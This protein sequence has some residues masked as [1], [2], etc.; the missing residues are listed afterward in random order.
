MENT[1]VITMLEALKKIRV[2]EKE[3]GQ[4]ADSVRR[5]SSKVSI[6]VSPFG[7]NK[8]QK[9]KIRSLIQSTKDLEIEYRTLK[10]RITY[11]NLFVSRIIDGVSY[12]LDD[13]LIMKRKTT[14]MIVKVINSLSRLQGENSLRSFSS[15][16]N[17]VVEL[18]YLEQ[19][20]LS[21]LKYYQDLI[22][23]IDSVLD[24]TLATQSL[25][26]LPKECEVFKV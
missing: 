24:V 12:T 10:K 4:N 7:D 3:I 14:D 11:T 9:D 21:E 1:K 20:K 8:T 18:M 19:D 26:E 25:L 6:E 17:A 16:K 5:Y 13:L 23:Y 2:I 15:D 22:N